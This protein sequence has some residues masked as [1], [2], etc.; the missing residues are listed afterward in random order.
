MMLLGVRSGSFMGR[1]R[2][3]ML[4]CEERNQ[5]GGGGTGAGQGHTPASA[6]PARHSVTS[7]YTLCHDTIIIHMD[8]G[9]R[10]CH[11][12][13]SRGEQCC[14]SGQGMEGCGGFAYVSADVVM[15]WMWSFCG[16]DHSV[17]VIIL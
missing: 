11:V 12:P 6:R 16:C 4:S 3:G 10:G 7:C 17:D 15:L 1:Q 14:S 2:D 5:R 13:T 9:S 8:N